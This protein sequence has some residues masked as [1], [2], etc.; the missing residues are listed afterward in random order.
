[1][2]NTL[3]DN[4]INNTL[5]GK[6]LWKKENITRSNTMKDIKLSHNK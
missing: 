1:M 3:R 2:K 6:L 5:R 4:V